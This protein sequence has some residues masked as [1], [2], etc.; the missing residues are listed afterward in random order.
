M[1]PCKDYILKISGLTHSGV[2]DVGGGQGGRVAGCLPDTSDWEISA[3]P[4][5]KREA[6]RK[7]KM[8]Q[9]RRKIEKRRWKIENGRRKSY[10]MRR[11]DVHV[12]AI[13]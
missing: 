3:E 9:K 8:E 13:K 12:T 10:K 4:T 2:T 7:R 11:G 5:G 1:D 6:R